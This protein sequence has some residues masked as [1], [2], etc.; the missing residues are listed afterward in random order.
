MFIP[1]REVTLNAK[2]QKLFQGDVKLL[3]P[4]KW[5]ARLRGKPE[6]NW[7]ELM[8]TPALLEITADRDFL[9]VV[10][11]HVADHQLARLAVF[12][13]YGNVLIHGPFHAKQVTDE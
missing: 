11:D 7:T 4:G 9:V 6:A 10:D 5:K 8:R 12:N 2:P 1:Q 13:D 3:V